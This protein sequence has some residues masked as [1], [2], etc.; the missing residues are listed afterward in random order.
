M[1]RD[2]F[3]S[4]IQVLQ[5]SQQMPEKNIESLHA[6]LQE[7]Y[8]NFE[9]ILI[10]NQNSP[11][12][13]E[14]IAKL[15]TTHSSIWCFK[16]DR[17]VDSSLCVLI[18][19]ENCIGDYVILME[20]NRDELDLIGRSIELAQK[21]NLE[22]I[23]GVSPLKRNFLYKALAGFYRSTMARLI[24]YHVPKNSTSFRLIT[25]RA[26]N[27]V[28]KT[29]MFHQQ[30]FPRIS[31][32]SSRTGTIE[33]QANFSRQN[34]DTI[35]FFNTFSRAISMIVF[36]SVVPLR[37]MTFLGIMGSFLALLTSVYI[38]SVALIK[39]DVVEG[40]ISS[41]LFI[42]IFFFLTLLILTFLCEYFHRLFA[43]IANKKEYDNVNETHSSVLNMEKRINVQSN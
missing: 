32:A 10:N 7:R 9:I 39:D 23:I 33:Y 20:P 17:L 36:N 1:K 35:S 28:V 16:L 19:L 34:L 40:W 6:Y 43:E 42:S 5:S 12:V 27:S 37:I 3:V 26:L 25:R 38:M 8:T 29:R 4:V 13:D 22:V 11:I 14:I 21:N 2:L 15:Q 24:D 18:G 30:L 41:N 31:L